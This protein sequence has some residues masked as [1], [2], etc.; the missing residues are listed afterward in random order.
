MAHTHFKPGQYDQTVSAFIIRTDLDQPRLL[1]HLHK[2]LNTLFQ[3]GGHIELNENPWQALKH[4]LLEE[5][6]Y[7]LEEL[8]ILQPSTPHITRLP[9]V[10]V[11]PVPV[12]HSSHGFEIWPDHFHT[13]TTYA[14]L[15]AG[16]PTGKPD[17]GESTD[18][19]WVSLA[20]LNNIPD[21]EII[22]NIRVIGR[23]VLTT[24]LSSWIPLPTKNYIA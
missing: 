9:G 3:P 17:D 23:Y 7:S 15:A 21:D 10:T 4:E 20:E 14:L 5:T 11:H 19:R 1:L 2:K 22:E 13:D 24:V 8:Q 16:G 12:I 18:M 6:G